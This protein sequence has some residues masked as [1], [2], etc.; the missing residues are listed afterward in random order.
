MTLQD[1]GIYPDQFISSSMYSAVENVFNQLQTEIQLTKDTYN[2][3][4]KVHLQLSQ[5]FQKIRK[6]RDELKARFELQQKKTTS[7]EGQEQLW[8]LMYSKFGDRGNFDISGCLK[9]FT[10]TLKT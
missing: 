3:I 6:E 9:N 4:D 7:M 8:N 2:A 1:Y 10:I 5:D